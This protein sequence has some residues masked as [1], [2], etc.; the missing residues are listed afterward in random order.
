MKRSTLETIIIV[1]ACLLFCF[2]GK[3]QGKVFLGINGATNGAGLSLGVESNN[4]A[5]T[6]Q[7]SHPYLSTEQESIY[8]MQ[9][10]YIYHFS[11]ENSFIVGLHGGGAYTTKKVIK[12]N[13]VDK[14]VQ[15][16]KGIGTIEVGKNWYT[17]RLSVYSSYIGSFN[18]GL[19]PFF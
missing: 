10:G 9:T 4:V 8:S 2:A 1:I 12:D 13:L 5:F 17:G 11:N 6:L 3:A 19:I 7:M 15:Q 14:E 16:F 18:Y